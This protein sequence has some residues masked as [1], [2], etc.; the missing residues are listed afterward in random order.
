MPATNARNMSRRIPNPRAEGPGTAR[1]PEHHRLRTVEAHRT[2]GA[3]V[4]RCPGGRIHRGGHP[5]PVVWGTKI[6]GGEGGS[7][8]L[9]PLLISGEGSPTSLRR[10]FGIPIKPRTPHPGVV[11]GSFGW[12]WEWPLVVS[13][14]CR[15]HG[16]GGKRENSYE[17]TRRQKLHMSSAFLKTEQ[18]LGPLSEGGAQIQAKR[19]L[20][21]WVGGT[22]TRWG[23]GGRSHRPKAGYDDACQTQASRQPAPHGGPMHTST[24]LR[25][26][27]MRASN[28]SSSDGPLRDGA[29]W[30]T[31]RADVANKNNTAPL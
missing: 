4:S 5:P 12:G 18:T 25:A 6:R 27:A 14:K 30:S 24:W 23:K 29:A 22:M 17:E 16:E 3:A 15:C 20:T 9:P 10:C 19:G 31:A 21:S 7:R 2:T 28:A 11:P 8:P 26:W 1:R 13:A